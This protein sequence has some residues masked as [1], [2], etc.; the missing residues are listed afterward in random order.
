L[1]FVQ[2]GSAYMGARLVASVA[3]VPGG[4]GAIEATLMAALSRLGMA[5]GA[6]TSGVLIYRLLTFWLNIPVGWV[7][8]KVAEKRGYV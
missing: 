3:P 6:A 2:L 7:G 4:L 1:S 8:L 5:A